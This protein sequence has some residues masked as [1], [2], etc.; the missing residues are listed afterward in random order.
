MLKAKLIRILNLSFLICSAFI[1]CAALGMVVNPDAFHKFFSPVQLVPDPI[2]P[3][4]S[5]SYYWDVK[6]YAE[7]VLKNHCVA[8]YPLWPL[9]ARI[10]FNPQTVE[11][12]AYSFL[13]LSTILFFISTPLL[14]LV[15]TKSLTHQYLAFL[16]V[17]AFTLNPMAI[18][19]V[20]GYT[21]SLFSILSI[22][23]IWLGLPQIKL[24]KNLQLLLIGCLTFIMSLSRPILIPFIVA[25][26]AA[27]G[28]LFFFRTLKDSTGWSDFFKIRQYTQ[29]AKII[30]TLWISAFLGY[31]LYG[32]F[33][34]RSR[35]DFF[36]PFN[37]QKLWGTKLGLHLELLLFPKSPLFDLLGLYF[38]ILIFLISFIFVYLKIKDKTPLVWVP[39]SPFWNVLLLYPPLLIVSYV[40]NYWRLKIASRGEKKA[41][42][43]LKTSDFTQTLSSNY[44]FWFCVYFPIVHSVL[45]F[46]TRDRLYSLGRY[47]FGVPFFFLA[48]GYLC[49]CIPGKKTYQALW[50]FVV[51]CAIALVEQWVNY[52]QNQWL[53]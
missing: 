43:P 19:R 16:G 26:A 48:L 12:A 3:S 46:F 5:I 8:F 2:P 33:C 11:Q 15:F 39:Q 49:C 27:L 41:L 24:N 9:L 37:D 25:S 4:R 21:E 31:S 29:E 1:L 36:A 34:W 20:I 47:I 13:R 53:G 45:I 35:G 32:A 6:S 28:T 52:G 18:F 23:L 7:M 14:I 10:L 30:L 40:V 38:P 17:L 51:I 22:I 42:V 50:W 44:I